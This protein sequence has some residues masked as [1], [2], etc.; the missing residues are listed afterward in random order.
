MY[1]KSIYNLHMKIYL[2]IVSILNVLVLLLFAGALF[3]VSMFSGTNNADTA[4]VLFITGLLICVLTPWLLYRFVQH[5]KGSF[6]TGLSICAVVISLFPILFW[7][8]IQ[9][10]NSYE[11]LPLQAPDAEILKP[12]AE[13]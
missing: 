10:S 8:Y 2:I 12:P 11:E 5:K 4:V 13:Y 1:V 6:K 7:G 3:G 9:A